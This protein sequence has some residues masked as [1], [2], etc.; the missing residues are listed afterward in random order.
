[1]IRYLIWDAGGTLF[2]TYPAV[3]AACQRALASFGHRAASDWLMDLFRRTTASALRAVAAT[4]D[5]DVEG[6]T[7]RFSAAYDAIEP[8]LQPPF[9]FVREVCVCVVEGGGA[10][11]VVTHRGRASLEG[12]LTAH[13]LAP[14]VE[15]CVTEDDPFPRKPDPASILALVDRHGLP[16]SQCLAIGDRNLDIVAGVRAGGMTCF[17]GTDSHETPADLEITSYDRLLAWLRAHAGAA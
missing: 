9:P 5:L 14:L 3:V 2:D 17:Y 8:E 11:Y 16:R 10:N 6:L 4:Y 15:D 13:D 7:A 12:L 1:L